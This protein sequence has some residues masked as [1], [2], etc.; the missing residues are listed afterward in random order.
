MQHSGSGGILRKLLCKEHPYVSTQNLMI[1][2][3]I[4]QDMNTL[5]KHGAVNT[6]KH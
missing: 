4:S 6:F 5:D 2:K 1:V 3:T